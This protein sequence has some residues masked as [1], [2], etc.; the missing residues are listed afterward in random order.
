MDKIK[1]MIYTALRDDSTATIGIRALLGNT[2]ATPYNVYHANLP[3]PLDFASSK[4]YITY[5]QLSG[6]FDTT[7]PRNNF[8]TMPKQETYQITVWGGDTT[9]SNDK[10]LDRVR[11]ILEG[12]H[13]TTNPTSD[14]KVFSIKCEWESADMWDDDYRIFYKSARFRIWLQDVT[15]TG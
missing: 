13:K 2:T 7:Y 15:I 3:D 1:D 10:I 5:F 14:A 12:K 8:S 9:T 11:Y 4:K 6:D